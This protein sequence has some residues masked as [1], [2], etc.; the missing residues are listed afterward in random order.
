MPFLASTQV[1]F[2]VDYREVPELGTNFQ[3]ESLDG[4][5]VLFGVP[6]DAIFL[7]NKAR[8]ERRITP[9]S[10]FKVANSLIGLDSLK[11]LLQPRRESVRLSA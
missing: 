2:A 11:L 8:A 9:A 1:F 6:K 7:S 4:T 10:T 3:K 5:F